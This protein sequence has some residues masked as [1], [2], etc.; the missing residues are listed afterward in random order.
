[1]LVFVSATRGPHGNARPLAHPRYHALAHTHP[2]QRHTK[3]CHAVVI[4]IL[5]TAVCRVQHALGLLDGINTTYTYLPKKLKEAGYVSHHIGKW[6][7]GYYEYAMTPPGT[8]ACI[9]HGE[10]ARVF[11]QEPACWHHRCPARDP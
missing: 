2:A 8:Y 10:C 5:A 11:A 4:L 7:N 3:P 9:K 1:M 6:H